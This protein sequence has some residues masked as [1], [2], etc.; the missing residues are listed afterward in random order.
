MD[1]PRA[2]NG[3]GGLGKVL[4]GD[5]MGAVNEHAYSRIEVPFFCAFEERVLLNTYD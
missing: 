1:A 5:R 3:F 2:A 4:K